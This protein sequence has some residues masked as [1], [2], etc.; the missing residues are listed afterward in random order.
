MNAKAVNSA[1]IKEPVSSNTANQEVV[2]P[3]V[4]DVKSPADVNIVF[5]VAIGTSGN[6]FGFFVDGRTASVWTNNSL[7][8][9]ALTHR[10]ATPS[11]SYIGYDLSKDGGLTW[12][13]NQ[14]NYD[15]TIAGFSPARYPQGGLIN[16]PGNTNPDNAMH[17]YIAALLDGSQGT[18]GSWG[19][20]GYGIKPLASGSTAWQAALTTTNDQRWF[21][22]DAFTVTQQG[23]VYFVDEQVTWDGAAS[24]YLGDIT[25]GTGIYNEG[26]AELEYSFENYPL[27]VNPDDGI[28]DIEIAFAPDGQTGYISVLSNL[29][30]ALPYTSYHPI[31]MKTV[32]GG[33]NWSDPIEVQLG[34]DDGLAA[35]QEFITDE[36]LVAYFD[37]EP[38]PP[39]NEIAYYIGYNQDL[40]VDAWGNPH[41]SGTC[42][43]ADLEAGTIATGTGYIAM[44]HIWSPDGGLTWQ[45]FKLA[46]LI[47][48]S[49]EWSGGGSTVSQYNR[50]QI[51]TTFDGSILFF[52]WLDSDIEEATDNTRPDIYFRE[53]IPYAGANGTHGENIVN[54]TSLSSAMWSATWGTMPYYVFSRDLGDNTVE[55]TIPFVYQKMTNDDPSLVA[56][57]YYIPDFKRTYAITSTDELPNANIASVSQNYPNPFSDETNINV[58]LVKG[59]DVSIEVY[60]L[61]GQKVYTNNYGYKPAGS[62][63]MSILS[64]N[65]PTGVYFYTVEAGFSK[66]TR[67]MVVK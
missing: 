19:G 4:P 47:Q 62:F 43:I 27:P 55:C 31:F 63:T 15:P 24:T 38:V 32:D 17:T 36:A 40:A 45:A 59:S 60:N 34:G 41:I 29:E 52:S 23:K 48:F 26:S 11:S 42:M 53:F 21:L 66:I 12:E 22:P 16:L 39:R 20:I 18:D 10:L 2:L 25:I 54:V 50:P 37:P 9:V 3:S 7:N 33:S 28:N 1:T 56:Q 67:K 46:D 51:S 57:F 30:T 64:D 61:T 14:V 44:F 35:I 8:T 13:L 6:A 5:P 58:T 65:M 49:A